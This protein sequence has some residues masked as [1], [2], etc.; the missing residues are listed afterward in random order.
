MLRV[1]NEAGINEF[2]YTINIYSLPH[3]KN[4][5][6]AKAT[7]KV[8]ETTQFTHDC[9]ADAIPQPEVCVIHLAIHQYVFSA[10]LNIKYKLIDHYY[11]LSGGIMV[12]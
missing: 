7:V 6:N 12:N 11:R 2:T 4:A 1:R 3:L 9:D 10:N 5:S 8:L